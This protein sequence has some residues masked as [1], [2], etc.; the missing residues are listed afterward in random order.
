[1]N[2]RKIILKTIKESQRET[3]KDGVDISLDAYIL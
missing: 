1:M 2:V 3:A